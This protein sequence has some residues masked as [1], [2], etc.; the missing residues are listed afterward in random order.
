MQLEI[1]KVKFKAVFETATLT[2]FIALAG[3]SFLNLLTPFIAKLI[4]LALILAMFSVML[5]FGLVY[6]KA[7]FSS[8]RLKAINSFYLVHQLLLIVLI[9]LA[10]FSL[11]RHFYT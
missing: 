6:K 10:L 9:L 1:S 4:A 8:V 11:V 7:Y 2:M 3:S 5:S